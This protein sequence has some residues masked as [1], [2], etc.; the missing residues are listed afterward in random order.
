MQRFGIIFSHCFQYSIKIQLIFVLFATVCLLHCVYFSSQH[1]NTWWPSNVQY[2]VF[3]FYILIQYKI[4]I[5]E[6]DKLGVWNP[7][8]QVHNS[9]NAMKNVSFLRDFRKY[10]KG[11]NQHI[12]KRSITLN[13]HSQKKSVIQKEVNFF[14]D[15][16]PTV[17]RPFAADCY[18]KQLESALQL[19]VKCRCSNCN[20]LF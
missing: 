12:L 16:E 6:N 14:P 1:T 13:S 10:I 17:P 3:I 20:I 5:Y 2:V 8:V 18:L 4:G 19:S 11:K 15:F 7:L 9:K